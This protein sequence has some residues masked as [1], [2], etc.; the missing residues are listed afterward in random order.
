PLQ[1]ACAEHVDWEARIANMNK[2]R[3][4]IAVT[5]LSCPNVY[6]GSAEVSLKAARMMNDD[7]ARAQRQWPERIRWFASLPWQHEKIALEEL[8]RACNG[9]A[10]GVMV[11]ANIAGKAL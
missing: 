4:D 3:V 6:W 10:V 8:A 9:G 1:A 5:S 11:L 2:A 7:M